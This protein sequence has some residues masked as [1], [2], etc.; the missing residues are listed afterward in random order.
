MREVRGSG[1]S[2]ENGI[3]GPFGLGTFGTK[4]SGVRGS[5]GS[6]EI[7]TACIF[8]FGTRSSE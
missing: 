8:R 7:E 4:S 6:G 3:V 5:A 1:D 2:A